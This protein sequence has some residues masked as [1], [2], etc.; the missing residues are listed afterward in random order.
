MQGR[1]ETYAR[2]K[3]RAPE[4]RQTSVQHNGRD[5][6]ISSYTTGAPKAPGRARTQSRIQTLEAG[7]T[8]LPNSS[9]I[10]GR[11]RSDVASHSS[12]IASDIRILAQRSEDD[13]QAA[14]APKWAARADSTS[15]S[16]PDSR[17]LATGIRPSLGQASVSERHSVVL[18]EASPGMGSLPRGPEIGGFN[19]AGTTSTT[20]PTSHPAAPGATAA[21]SASQP[22]T[23]IGTAKPAIG[24]G[25]GEVVCIQLGQCGNQLGLE[26]YNTLA[27]EA[28]QSH[29]GWY[30][31][32][33][34]NAFFRPPHTRQE[35]EA[36]D[37]GIKR[38]ARCVLIDMEPKVIE[39]TLE[40]ASKSKSNA[41]WTYSPHTHYAKQSGSGNNWAYGYS[42]HG[43]SS[44]DAIERMIIGELEKCNCISAIIL[45]QSLAGGTG[46]GLGTYVTELV[47]DL[48]PNITLLNVVVWPYRMGEVI[49]QHYNCILSLSHL[50]CE[51]DG[52]IAIQNDKIH[53][54][55]S[56]YLGLERPSFTDMNAVI[57]QHLASVLLPAHQSFRT[58]SGI[59]TAQSLMQVLLNVTDSGD[60]GG[61][62]GRRGGT[63]PLSL[64]GTS[65]SVGKTDSHTRH[66]LGYTQIT[67][68]REVQDAN[69]TRLLNDDYF[70]S[71]MG[72]SVPGSRSQSFSSSLSK[73]DYDDWFGFDS[74]TSASLVTAATTGSFFNALSQVAGS[75]PS[76]WYPDAGSAR[77]PSVIGLDSIVSHV[78]PHP[79][80]RL[81]TILS[82]PQVSRAAKDF[83]STTWAYVLRH[84]HQSATDLYA[85]ER[86][87]IDWRVALAS[88]EF[89][90]GF[91][92]DYATLTGSSPASL[93]P[94]YDAK[95]TTSSHIRRG[96]PSAPLYEA[97]SVPFVVS[98][99]ISGI[100][101]GTQGRSESQ[102]DRLDAW[103]LF[104][105]FPSASPEPIPALKHP[106][107]LPEDA[108]DSSASSPS[109]SASPYHRQARRRSGSLNM[110]SSPIH[111]D[112]PIESSIPNKFLS[113]YVVLRGKG[114]EYAANCHI[115]GLP[116]HAP[117][118][119]VAQHAAS[120]GS[121][122]S[123]R[124][125]S[126]SQPRGSKS[127][128]AATERETARAFA[129]ALGLGA[130][131]DTR[132]SGF[133][134]PGLF[135]VIKPDPLYIAHCDVMFNGDERSGAVW[136]VSKRMVRPLEL[137]VSKAWSMYTTNAYIHHYDH[138]G[139]GQ[140][141]FM[142]C[143]ATL[144]S[145]LGDLREL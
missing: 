57:S 132:V 128:S 105:A 137:V 124:P 47:R 3:S 91:S 48:C 86:R 38:I 56:Q 121:S 129:E 11:L 1:N 93:L 85:E 127:G 5:P 108:V 45:I 12:Y 46:S 141:E 140:S 37:N 72:S 61:I 82:F 36:C 19:D 77:A 34:A 30:R 122:S 138:Y 116:L 67:S 41:M 58:T 112:I 92:L 95:S 7:R 103:G 79:S 130:I 110:A 134:H 118:Q 60:D 100:G 25:G 43:P 115:A 21:M 33:I 63:H 119:F 131:D 27:H 88:P 65:A 113:M 23:P 120:V 28:L 97:Q 74:A 16:G 22:S 143:F 139:I 89:V 9:G 20:R 114:S 81:S 2:S 64:A 83:E 51:S 4:G 39:E 99:A 70:W 59:V 109:A 107:S 144:E 31:Q 10:A 84:L 101:Q 15:T 73:V 102:V 66:P 117:P 145:V 104:P 126:A 76:G 44:R 24:R 49:V 106:Q 125:R 54:I 71:A 13:P 94:L 98:G 26:L 17:R 69:L 55:C 35:H 80:Y 42:I 78:F 87:F 50:V 136:G 18:P 75:S 32:Y 90:R 142:D 96:P 133:R 111:S 68:L 53:S 52:L 40:K 135:S 8:E 29:C 123:G 6:G 62:V 14:G